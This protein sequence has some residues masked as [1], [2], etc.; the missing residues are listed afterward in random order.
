MAVY[1]IL[2]SGILSGGQIFLQNISE[3]EPTLRERYEVVSRYYAWGNLGLIMGILAAITWLQTRFGA[4]LYP[5]ATKTL[6]W[7]L[8]LGLIGSV[9]FST[10]LNFLI[11]EPRKYIDHPELIE[12]QLLVASWASTLS[13]I[14][15]IGLLG[16]LILSSVLTRR[17]RCKS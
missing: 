10:F 1:G 12:S 5:V 2:G 13:S 9:V 6:F 16:L 8:H 15:F 14:A 11:P 17:A 7:F 4:M 3:I